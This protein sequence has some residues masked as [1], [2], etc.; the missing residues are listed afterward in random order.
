MSSRGRKRGASY[1]RVGPEVGLR[2]E[3]CHYWIQMTGKG[4]SRN[5]VFVGDL[6]RFP[7]Q[8][9]AFLHA[10]WAGSQAKTRVWRR[11]T[12][13]KCERPIIAHSR[14]PLGAFS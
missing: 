3:Q 14:G 5:R 7:R 9:C 2:S 4:H 11:T 8:K 1:T 6:Q 10:L 12:F 13:G